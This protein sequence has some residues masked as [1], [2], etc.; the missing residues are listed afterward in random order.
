MVRAEQ[1]LSFSIG[2][3]VCLRVALIIA[4]GFTSLASAQSTL[5]LPNTVAPARVVQK[6]SAANTSSLTIPRLQRGPTLEDFLSMQPQGEIALQMAKVTGFKQRNPHD[7][8]DI[9]EPTDAY[10]GYD[11][12]NLYVVFVCFD[13]P[14]KVRAR[15]SVRED[16]QD[17]DQVEI[18]LDT[19]HDRRRAYAFQTT[20]LGV[21]WDAIYT[22][23]SREEQTGEHFDV[24]FDTVWDSRGKVTSHGFVVWIAI[25]FKS[26]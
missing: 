10:L 1:G 9:S 11:Q 24:S 19:F 14:K 2:V 3:M 18:I 26:L 13:D 7:G 16:I 22:E 17:D 21:Q 25:P 6:T 23:A 20:P 5:P 15:M 12:K 4:A 8:E